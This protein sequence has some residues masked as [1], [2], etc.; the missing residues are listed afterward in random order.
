MDDDS[1]S[2]VT[3]DR[4]VFIGEVVSTAIKKNNRGKET[5]SDK[6]DKNV[7]NRFLALPIFVAIMYVVY[8]VAITIG[9]IGT[10]WINDTLF[11]EIIQGNVSNWMVNAGV[12]DW[13]Q[14]LVSDGIISGVG[15]VLGFVP[16]II[17]LFLFLSIP[18]S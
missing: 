18:L 6:I 15:T 2:V 1:E 5:T 8:Y 12:A 17:L 11:G 10:D 3:G 4:Y 14:G 16:Q 7:T 9:T 13:L